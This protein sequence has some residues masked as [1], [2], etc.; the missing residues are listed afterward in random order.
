MVLKGRKIVLGV[1]GSIAAYKSVLLTRLLIEEGAEVKVILTETAKQFVGELT[2]STLS[3]HPVISNIT[4]G[5]SWNS[6]VE[7]GLWADAFI[8]APA[9]A[10]TLAKMAQGFADNMLLA[11]YLSAKCPVW[12]AP[13]MDLDMW[14]HPAT[15]KNV[16]LLQSYG[17]QLIDV[18]DGFLASG[19]SGKGRM[20]EPETIV[21]KIIDS[22]STEEGV[23]SRQSI[24]VTA[25]PTQEPLD[26]VR[27]LGNRSSG[28]MGVA[29][30]REAL[31]LGAIVH[32][33]KGPLQI[34]VPKHP[35]LHIYSVNTA[36]EMFQQCKSLF[37]EMTGAILAAAVSDFRPAYFSKE[38][39]KSSKDIQKI[40]LEPTRDIAEYLGRQKQDHQWMVGFALETSDPIEN[41]RA[42]LKKKNFD[43]IVLNATGEGQSPFGSD[44]NQI[45]ILF[46]D[47]G[48]QKY[49]Q[50]SKEAVAHDILE[51]IV[52]LVNK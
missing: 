44:E 29:L 22:F 27:Y 21:S 9:T 10:H 52:S 42:K 43:F 40:E 39:I 18:E 33:V 34:D 16:D 1:T 7:L 20:A 45:E 48:H 47:E 24:L 32:L 2:F 30:S 51:K 23:L 38:K 35:N 19:L 50:K 5:K 31:K 46:G 28:K 15:K 13:A 4:D 12:F 6:H 36:D 41:A 26:P 25:G 3:N 49:L 37:P 11:T 14:R 17:H 8:I